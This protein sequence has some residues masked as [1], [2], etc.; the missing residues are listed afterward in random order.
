M[1]LLLPVLLGMAG[2]AVDLGNLYLSHNKLQSAVDA[3]ALAGSL[4]LPADPDLDKGIVE[5]AVQD[6]VAENYPGAVVENVD[7]GSEVRSVV[8][9]ASAEVPMLLMGALG[10]NAKTVRAEA[11]AG[12]NNIEVVLVLDNTGSMKGT[13]IAM[14]KD[15][16]ENLIDLILPDGAHPD[17]KV[18]LVGFRGK[19]KVGDGVDGLP[20]GCRNADGSVNEVGLHPDHM[21]D[22]YDLPWYYRQ[23]VDM[24]T[25]SDL[26]ETLP[27]TDD[28]YTINQALSQHTAEGAA[29]GT[30]ISEG[31]KWGRHVLTPEAPYEEGSDDDR[32]R[33]IMILLTDGD[34]ED[35]FCGGRYAVGYTPNN[36]WT[37]AYF[38][39]GDDESHCEDGGALNQALLDEAQA[40]KD[41]GVEIFTIRYGNS[42]T[43]DVWLMKQVASSREGTD[44]HYFNAPTSYDIDDVFKKIGRQ[45]GWRLLR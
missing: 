41:A 16:A 37:N 42:D 39:M 1:A 45:L 8:V 5:Q 17:C 38:R 40:A 15:A 32:T 20:G 24:D 36:Y 34:T 23:R 11:E 21:D 35:G 3:G 30:V 18:G 2:F 43:T 14:T 4:E 28:K 26:P 12:F 44:D 25:C 29:S 19:V 9:R 27:L 22:Y 33:K 31:V 7:P 10:A 13:P 6:M